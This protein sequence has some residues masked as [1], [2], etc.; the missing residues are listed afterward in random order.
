MPSAC[1][2]SRAVFCVTTGCYK[3]EYWP[4]VADSLFFL[5][6]FLYR[7]VLTG[8]RRESY[9]EWWTA[10]DKSASFFTLGCSVDTAGNTNSRCVARCQQQSAKIERQP[11]KSGEA[12]FF[13][14]VILSFVLPR[15]PGLYGPSASCFLE[16]GNG[17]A[18][19][20]GAVSGTVE[21]IFDTV[22]WTLLQCPCSR[23]RVQPCFG[24]IPVCV[25][26][27]HGVFCSAA[28]TTPCPKVE[29]LCSEV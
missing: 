14:A 2:S 1:K 17:R 15:V 9:R 27:C 10:I 12:V 20:W 28:P 19:G 21:K 22:T 4:C 7:P 26:L 5:L 8:R 16:I 29:D 24:A 25:S 23:T 3:L 13:F 6:S 11:K 18:T